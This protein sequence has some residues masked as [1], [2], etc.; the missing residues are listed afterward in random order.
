M[1]V[2][3]SYA[4]SPPLAED[5]WFTDP[6][7]AEAP[8][9]DLDARSDRRLPKPRPQSARP[10]RSFGRRGPQEVGERPPARRGFFGRF[11]RF[12]IAV[13]IGV[14][15]TLAA[16]TD[17]AKELL[18]TQAP[19]LAWA[20]SV[21]PVKSLSVAAPAQQAVPVPSLSAADLDT[22]RRSVEQLAARQ[23][24]MAQS[25][26]ALQAVDED[27]RQKLSAMPTSQPQQAAAIP[28]SK[29]PQAMR[30]PPPPA[31][32]ASAARPAPGAGAPLPLR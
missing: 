28:Q 23:D 26:V 5:E 6:I 19:T 18:A 3:M 13:S 21:S 22:V 15:G 20:L 4:Q 8:V 30:M 1:E 24:Q 29:P 7:A 32:S 2:S 10:P 11:V 9:R 17:F 27:I 14:G 25:V 12:V 16:Q 31:Q